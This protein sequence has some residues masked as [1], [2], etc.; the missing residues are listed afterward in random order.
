MLCDIARKTDAGPDLVVQTQEELGRLFVA[1][2]SG[3]PMPDATKMMQ[4]L[5]VSSSSFF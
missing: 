4:T 3:P 5:P 1:L 2:H